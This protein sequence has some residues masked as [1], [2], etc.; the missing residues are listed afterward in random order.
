MFNSLI[1]GTRGVLSLVLYTL[2]TVACCIAIFI[3]AFI[4]LLLPIKPIQTGCRRILTAFA[5]GWIAVNNLIQK[6]FNGVRLD[7]RGLDNLDPKG[8]YMVVA[9]HQSWVDILV[10]QTVFYRKIPFLKFFLKK[11]LFWFP[12]LGQAWWALD[13]P[14]MKR[15]SRQFLKKNPHLIGKDLEITKRACDKFRNIPVSVMNFVEGTR[16]TREKH[17]RQRSPY[18]HLLRTKAGG[19][20]FVLAAMGDK[21]QHIVDVTIAYPQ[22]AATFWDFVCG[23]VKEI[24]VRVKTL[25]IDSEMMGDYLQDPQ[26]KRGFQKWLNSLWQEKDRDLTR[27]LTR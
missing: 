26:F 23:R 27:M 2:N 14:F 15:Y 6:L 13:F 22:G 12:F 4:K 5:N 16:F 19:M 8:W 7:V 10:L 3:V 17:S 25:P 9:N 18:T 11:E 24:K 21:L 20:A 1:H